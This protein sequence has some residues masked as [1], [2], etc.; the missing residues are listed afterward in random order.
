[1]KIK[2]LT[3]IVL[4]LFC[5]VF[6]GLQAQT[7]KDIDGNVYK[8]VTI[9]K[10]IWM[11]ENLKTTKYNDGRA[12]PLVTNNTSWIALTTP[13]YCWYNNDST[14]N[15][16]TYGALYNWY[17]VNTKKLCP[18]GWHIPSDTEFE[19]LST[20]LGS[21]AGLRLTKESELFPDAINDS[22]FSAINTGHRGFVSNILVSI[23]KNYE[24]GWWGSSGSLWRVGADLFGGGIQGTQTYWLGF[25][26]RC[27]KDN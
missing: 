15:K 10:Q 20:Y 12:I 19:I 2:K 16:K 14:A 25:S 3:L 24:G 7:V 21:L 13:A 8:T 26:V 23:F 5:F 9:G 27:I 4:T 18:T 11:E 22:K 1:M 17:T 6:T